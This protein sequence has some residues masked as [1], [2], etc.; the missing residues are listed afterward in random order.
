MREVY[1]SKFWISEI[2]L[3]LM[4][5]MEHT[6]GQIEKKIEGR[7]FILL[8]IRNSLAN[9]LGHWCSG[10][11]HFAVC[12]CFL[13][14]FLSAFQSVEDFPFAVYFN[15]FWASSC[16]S[17][18]FVIMKSWDN[19]KYSVTLNLIFKSIWQDPTAIN[20]FLYQGTYT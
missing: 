20:I 16:Y 5:K 15:S 3:H 1:Q 13:S 4:I 9:V 10:C 7:T 14:S 11:N 8:L 18:L 6:W 2:W 17:V 19:W 12:L